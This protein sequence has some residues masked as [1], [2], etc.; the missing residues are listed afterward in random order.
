MTT[1]NNWNR[2]YLCICLLSGPAPLA[3][4]VL[5]GPQIGQKV[6]DPTHQGLSI[7]D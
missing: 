5:D 4:K 1:M 2:F 7:Y 3:I 6:D